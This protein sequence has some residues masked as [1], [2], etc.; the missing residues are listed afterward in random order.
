MTQ[1]V[2]KLTTKKP[3]LHAYCNYCNL[4]RTLSATLTQ[5]QDEVQMA[6]ISAFIYVQ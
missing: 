1:I 2:S 3:K 4:F 5:F 6:L